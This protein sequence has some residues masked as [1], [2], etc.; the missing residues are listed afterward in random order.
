[1]TL[2]SRLASWVLACALPP[3]DLQTVLG[4]LEEECGHAHRSARWYWGQ[5][6]RSLPFLMLSGIQRGGWLPTFGVAAA[7]VAAQATIELTL[8]FALSSLFGPDWS[9]AMLAT[10]VITLGS[11]GAL[12]FLA[13]RIR[14]GAA[15][16]LTATVLVAISVQLIVKSGI[17]L[18][19]WTQLATLFLAPSVVFAAGVLSLRTRRT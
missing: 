1:M 7:T 8:K 14:P 16:V 6:L 17:G 10:G 2:R 9:Q 4:D 11:L 18:S 13:T 5:I 19:T 3:R 15:T 12:T